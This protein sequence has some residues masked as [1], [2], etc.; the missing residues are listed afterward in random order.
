MSTDLILKRFQ[1]AQR[2]LVLQASDLS[3]GTISDMVQNDVIDTHP[4]YQRRERWSPIKQSAL[5]ESFLLNVPVPPIYLAEDDYGRYS[6]VDGKQRIMAIH[7]FMSGSLILTGLENFNK[8]I[9]LRIHDM[10]R[11]IQNSLNIRPYTRVITL[12]K[13]SNPNLKFEVFIRLNRGGEVME[14]QE[15]RNVAFRG[16]LNDLVYHLSGN[17]FLKN[18]LKIKDEKS[19]M[20]RSMMDAE[21]VLR[22]LTLR[23]S[24]SDFSGNYRIE[25]DSF[26]SS[27]QLNRESKLKE[28]RNSFNSSIS[29]CEQVWGK[30]AFKRANDGVWREQFLT[31]MYD[32]Q[33]IAADLLTENQKKFAIL[34]REKVIEK[35]INL[36]RNEEFNSAVRVGTNTPSRI[37]FRVNEI[38]KILKK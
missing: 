26:M 18:Q 8:L 13:Q 29:F 28:Y 5:I 21:L 3:L 31:G 7:A 30:F 15:L 33:M 16:P 24:W 25:M 38:S 17:D 9:G 27:N 35:T 36:F 2:E 14:A 19:Q 10:P 22:Y 34:N 32:A 11:E 20:Y 1:D 37:R 23:E 6:V 4:S 12:L